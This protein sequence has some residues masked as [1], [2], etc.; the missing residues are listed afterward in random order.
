M[1][2]NDG[3]LQQLGAALVK[4]LQSVQADLD[5]PRALLA[6][7]G[8]ALPAADQAA[9]TSLTTAASNT[10][11]AI[12]GLAQPLEALDTAVEGGDI[13]GILSATVDLVK[14]VGTAIDSV[15]ALG[16]A[17]TSLSGSLPGVTPG[18]VAAFAADFAEKL[19]ERAVVDYL[20]GYRPVLLRVLAL[21][22]VVNVDVS[23]A[24]PTDPAK[25]AYRHADLELSNLGG[26]LSGGA[27]YLET[28]YGWGGAHFDAATLLSRISNLT[29]QFGAATPFDPVTGTLTLLPFTVGATTGANP[30]GLA[31]TL[32]AALPA[33]TAVP[34]PSLLP[35][36]WS[37][38]LQTQGSLPA[39]VTVELLPPGK[40][41][42][43]APAQVDGEIQ[44][45]VSRDPDQGSSSL[46]LLSLPGI[47]SID[48]AS[49]SMLIGAQF[50]WDAATASASGAFTAGLAL[51]G[52]VL[53]VGT[54]DADGFIG[55]LISAAHLQAQF[56]LQAGWAGDRGFYLGGT[57]G[58]GATIGVHTAVGPFTLDS[59]TLRL[60]ASG[61]ALALE[62]S[63]SGSGTLGPITASVDRI[64]ASTVLSLSPGNLGPAGLDVAFKPPNGLGL[65]VDAGPISGG[66]YI[67]FDTAK[68][69]YSG[70][71]QLSLIDIGITAIGILDTHSPDGSGGFS[72]I[73][74]LTFDLP[75]I[76]LGFGFTLTGVGG[77]CGINRTMVLDALQSALRAHRLDSILFP[78][79]PVADAP[80]IISDLKTIFPPATGRYVFG[81]MLQIGWGTPSLITVELGVILELPDPVRIALLGRFSMALPDQSTALIQIQID[82]LGT[83][84]TGTDQLS[85]DGTMYDS[86]ILAFDLLGDMALR[87]DWGDSPEFAVSLGGFNPQYQPP[88]GFPPLQRLT[89]SIGDGDNPRLSCDAYLAVTSNS[90]QFGAGAQLY[91]AAAGFSIDGQISFDTLLIFSPFSFSVD[92]SASLQVKFE[93][94]TLLGLYVEAA[95]SGPTPWVVQGTVSITILFFSVGVSLHLQWGETR[96]VPLPAIPVLPPLVAALND[97]SNWS[98][99]LP[100]NADRTVTLSALPPGDTDIIVHPM[101]SL[102]VRQKVVP[103]DVPVTL[104]GNGTPAD[105]S[106]FSLAGASIGAA[107]ATVSPVTDYFAR[108]QFQQM[109]AAQKLSAPGYE[110][111]D[112]GLAIGDT[113]VTGGNDV[114]STLSYV[115]VYIEDPAAHANF[116]T[117]RTISS[118]VLGA[119]TAQGASALGATRRGGLSTYTT[120]A[121][122]SPISVN[123][124]AYVVASTADL[125]VRGDIAPGAGTSCTAADAALAAHLRASPQDAGTLQVIP[126]F[127]AVA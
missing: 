4:A 82:V 96:T 70:V 42:V 87:L 75:P 46:S 49:L 127:E 48:A 113:A 107:P 71:L 124:V 13:A 57:T 63:V 12:E 117:L 16:A 30:P 35:D 11:H 39:G 98:A 8:L 29:I 94:L 114:A 19:L 116:L 38:H 119:L 43:K 108:A 6:G 21:L 23:P 101:G 123:P 34:L 109:S 102:T 37:V 84:D 40:L 126:L 90:F 67:S 112:S 78:P 47:A 9:L 92:I 51:N 50:H 41:A 58:I 10:V 111:F 73:L 20:A 125:T 59:I 1:A 18:D 91:A 72:F 80:Q 61:G 22:G 74:I 86:Y 105:G 54:S 56:S 68:G 76:Q 93:S 95:F 69:E 110:L 120:P 2:D 118:E 17:L 65:A 89:V 55:E 24:D 26:L 85:I 106:R 31:A 15:H 27:T 122:S 81:P 99:S 97:V 88:A 52:A 53:S 60:D 64:G 32:Q 3:I 5:S 77:I 100:A 121:M 28:L 25:P 115:E 103:L 83:V 45:A 33:G 44:L 79:D 62:S 66:G 7:M 14:A 36:G 104:F